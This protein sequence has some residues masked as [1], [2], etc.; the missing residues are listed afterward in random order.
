MKH[1]FQLTWT[2]QQLRKSMIKAHD[3]DQNVLQ[4]TYL[5]TVELTLSLDGQLTLETF[6]FFLIFDN[7]LNIRQLIT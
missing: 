5:L 6:L 2:S 7:Q 4:L 3:N 1:F